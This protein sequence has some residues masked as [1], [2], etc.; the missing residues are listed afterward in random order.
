MEYSIELVPKTEVLEQP[1][2]IKIY[3]CILDAGNDFW[4][5]FLREKLPY[6]LDR[7]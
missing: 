5:N 7:I 1:L 4:V 2:L 6:G 3:R